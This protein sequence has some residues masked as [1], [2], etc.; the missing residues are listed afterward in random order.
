MQGLVTSGVMGFSNLESFLF[1]KIETGLKT[2][3]A[4]IQKKIEMQTNHRSGV[5]GKEEMFKSA[6]QLLLL[7]DRPEEADDYFAACIKQLSRKS[8]DDYNAT[9]CL[10][11]GIQ[12]LHH[13]HLRLAA[14]CLQRALE[15][16]G[17]SLQTR[18][19][20]CAALATLFFKLGMRRPANMSVDYALSLAEQ[21]G[22]EMPRAVLA[23]LKVEFLVLNFLRQHHKLSDLV[24]WPRRE[25]IAG[26]LVP[27][28]NVL[29]DIEM[30]KKKIGQY[31]LLQERLD[32]LTLLAK[33]AYRQASCINMA[34][35]HIEKVN[36]AGLASYAQS[37]RIELALA[38]TA[39]GNVAW[40]QAI[41]QPL[42]ASR[43]RLAS[44]NDNLEFEYCQAKL[45]EM[46]HREDGYISHYRQYTQAAIVQIRRACAYITV[47]HLIRTPTTQIPKDNIATRLPGK[48]RRAY[49]FLLENLDNPRLSV[50]MV[51]DEIGV[52]ERSLQLTFR[53]HLAQS[54][55]EVI[56]RCRMENIRSDLEAGATH[57][58]STLLDVASRWGI[59]S[60]SS[61][62]HS[63]QQEFNETPR[64]TIED[65]QTRL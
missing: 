51:A 49:R 29:R 7:L 36:H 6:A 54:P 22:H 1:G 33:L 26:E 18:I 56:R 10:F 12:N 17:T 52:T 11:T 14:S 39:A 58:G 20:S 50:K 37:A 19:E 63:Y 21:D 23:V 40:V 13:N 2:A 15:S 48:Y 61:L 65:F 38:A 57:A 25:E 5:E 46:Q 3:L 45:A 34:L 42:T 64:Q 44:L 41:L 24:F 9:S 53:A 8:K 32:F 16:K 47:P 59:G 28:E 55:S 43:T 62:G 35:E 31:E 27:I 30:C 60:R 4:S